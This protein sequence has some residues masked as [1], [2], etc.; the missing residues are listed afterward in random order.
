MNSMD[1]SR[2]VENNP[3]SSIYH[4]KEWSRL[5]EMVHNYKIFILMRED[6]ILPI[7]YVKSILFG[8]RLISI[9]FG[10]YGGPIGSLENVHL[11][12]E[13][14]NTIINNTNPDFVEIR[15]PPEEIRRI[16]INHS[17]EERVDYYTFILDL[18]IGIKNIWNNLEKRTRNGISRS[19][20]E[21]L[22][23]YRAE[24]IQDVDI[25]YDIY[26]KT[27][28]R[29]GSPPQPKS[30]FYN[31]WKLL[32]NKNYIRIYFASYDTMPISAAIFFTY[33]KKIHY[34]YSCS[35]Y[36]Y[37]K[38]RGND[39]LLWSVIEEFCEEGFDIFDFGRTRFNS[40]VYKY[41]R[42]WGGKATPM[43][44]Y[45]KFVRKRLQERQEIKY[46]NISK[47][48]KKYMSESIAKIIGPWIIKQVG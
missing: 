4:T 10:D 43:P 6:C 48:W 7:A 24:S 11:L 37:R 41:K 38:K 16:L 9:P 30:F 40:G 45:Y 44:Y 32:S 31:M 25:F 22:E 35:L 20:R 2:I 47:L 15:S 1:W 14:L 42:G 34:A 17:F 3:K 13:D 21:G 33:G 12:L 46:A 36:E 18:T 29:L 8:N 23:L 26:L 28:K 39:F 19:L 27:M 5:L